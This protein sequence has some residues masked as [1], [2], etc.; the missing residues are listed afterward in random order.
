MV[1]RSTALHPRSSKANQGR[2]KERKGCPCLNPGN[3]LRVLF[4]FLG[5]YQ[6]SQSTMVSYGFFPHPS[7]SFKYKRCERAMLN[8]QHSPRVQPLLVVFM[9]AIDLLWLLIP[10]R[11]GVRV[12]NPHIKEYRALGIP[13]ATSPN[14]QSCVLCSIGPCTELFFSDV[15]ENWLDLDVATHYTQKIGLEVSQLI[16][17]L[18][19]KAPS[20]AN[21]CVIYCE[22]FSTRTY[23][24]WWSY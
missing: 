8:I 9:D 14:V 23:W 15:L 5:G 16:M 21:H 19:Y 4:S 6:L 18:D 1:K 24:W 12:A 3:C 20:F 7:S 2:P 13:E 11:L 22:V 17:T 10:V